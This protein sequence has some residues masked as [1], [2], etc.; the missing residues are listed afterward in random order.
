MNDAAGARQIGLE[1]TEKNTQQTRMSQS[2]MT[3]S[4]SQVSHGVNRMYMQGELVLRPGQL[5]KSKMHLR[6]SLRLTLRAVIPFNPLAPCLKDSRSSVRLRSGSARLIA[7]GRHLCAGMWP[8]DPPHNSLL[9]GRLSLRLDLIRILA[10]LCT[11]QHHWYRLVLRLGQ[12]RILCARRRRATSVLAS[13]TNVNQLSANSTQNDALLGSRARHRFDRT[14]GLCSKCRRR[15]GIV[16]LAYAHSVLDAI[17]GGGRMHVLL[18]RLIHHEEQNEGAV[19]RIARH[20]QSAEERARAQPRREHSVL[21]EEQRAAASAKAPRGTG[22]CYRDSE[23][24]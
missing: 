6:Q 24:E 15:G 3:R 19:L 18:M 5:R 8:Q 16:R 9:D 1:H 22:P 17:F 4:Q 23:T 20:A 12:R 2:D 13:Y 10:V 7:R 14:G 21:C 11:A